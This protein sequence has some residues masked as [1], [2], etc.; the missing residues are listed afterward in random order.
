MVLR[1]IDVLEAAAHQLGQLYGLL[2]CFEVSHERGLPYQLFLSQ[3]EKAGAESV[4][5]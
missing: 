3:I 4:R 1:E 2:R 5:R